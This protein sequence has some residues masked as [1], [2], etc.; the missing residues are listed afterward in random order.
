ME[1]PTVPQTA[2]GISNRIDEI[3]FNS[4]FMLEL[5][6]IA[7]VEHLMKSSAVHAPF[8][9]LH[10]HGIGDEVLRSFGSSSKMN[11]EWTFLQDLHEIGWRAADRW[12]A[13]NLTAVGNR[14]TID[15]S[16]LLPQNDGSLRAPSVIKQQRPTPDAE[17]RRV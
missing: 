10:V 3:S 1:R 4:T 2:R 14:S 9:L 12:L 5:G 8:R 11:N 17:P 7:F 13:E 6:A 16:G 15:L